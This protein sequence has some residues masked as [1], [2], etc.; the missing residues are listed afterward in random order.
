MATCACFSRTLHGIRYRSR[1]RI[2]VILRYYQSEIVECGPGHYIVE[3]LLATAYDLRV[4]AIHMESGDY[5]YAY[6][7]DDIE[8]TS[9]DANDAIV[10]DLAVC[11]AECVP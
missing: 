9:G 7:H 4:R 10:A 3:D 8:L 11:E 6:D 1:E 2:Y 5:I